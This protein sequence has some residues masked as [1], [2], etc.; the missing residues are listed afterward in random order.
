MA[1]MAGAAGMASRVSTVSTVS[2]AGAAAGASGGAAAQG[3]VKD[4][5]GVVSGNGL[6][7]PVQLPVNVSG[8]SVN[9]VGIGDPAFGNESVNASGEGPGARRA[10]GAAAG[11]AQP[12][13]QSQ[14]PGPRAVPLGRR[15]RARRPRRPALSRSPAREPTPPCPPSAAAPP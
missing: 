6:Q 8:N 1:G 7:L 14:Q 4:S 9:V 15:P 12:A 3:D 11:P 13:A 10:R 2:T 5:P